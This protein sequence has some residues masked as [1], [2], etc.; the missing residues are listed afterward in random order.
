MTVAA[1]A[2]PLQEFYETP[3]V[4]LRS[5]PDRAHRQARMLAEIL[6]GVTGPAVIEHPGTSIAVHPGQRAHIDEYFDTVIE[7]EGRPDDDRA[8]PS[9][10]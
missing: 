2:N 9:H 3:G 6:R 1:P 10:L 7:I 8:R 5:G 4:P